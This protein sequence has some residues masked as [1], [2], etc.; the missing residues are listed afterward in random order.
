MG[1]KNLGSEDERKQCAKEMERILLKGPSVVVADE[2]HTFRNKEGNLARAI[3]S[4][5]TLYR[6]A[7]SG[8]PLLNTLEEYLAILKWLSIED[9]HK[10]EL[11]NSKT[12]PDFDERMLK[13]VE[14]SLT[15]WA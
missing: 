14:I 1:S 7:L 6:I 13:V 5:K 4:I 15:D 2:A 3:A 12:I 8:T 9:R 11:I 10:I